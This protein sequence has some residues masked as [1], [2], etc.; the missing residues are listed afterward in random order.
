MH[1][2]ASSATRWMVLNCYSFLNEPI[3]A[4]EKYFLFVLY[5]QIIIIIII[6]I[7]T[8]FSALFKIMAD[9]Q[10]RWLDYGRVTCHV[11]LTKDRRWVI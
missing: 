5:K 1:D 2:F 9:V 11:P 4:H 10:I 8:F 7:M 3:S 6:I